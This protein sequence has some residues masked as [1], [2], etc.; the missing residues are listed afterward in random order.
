M[1]TTLIVTLIWVAI[2]VLVWLWTGTDISGGD[3]ESDN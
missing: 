1:K 3:D 2:I